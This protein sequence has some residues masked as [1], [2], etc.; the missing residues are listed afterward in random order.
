[1]KSNSET[2]KYYKSI[3]ENYEKLSEEDTIKYITLAQQ[4]DTFARDLIVNSYIYLVLN[5][6]GKY[7]GESLT[8][9]DFIQEG[10]MGLVD[11]IETYDIEKYK[12]CKFVQIA[13]TVI[14]RRCAKAYNTDSMIKLPANMMSIK[15]GIK[16]YVKNYECTYGIE[17]RISDIAEHFHIT[18]SQVIS[19]LNVVVSI[20]SFITE[21]QNLSEKSD[22]MKIGQE[23]TSN[24]K[25]LEEQE[26]NDK[27]ERFVESLTPKQN[28][29]IRALAGIDHEVLTDK[30]IHQKYGIS[31]ISVSTIKRRIRDAYIYQKEDVT[32]SNNTSKKDI[33]L[34]EHG[35]ALI[36]GILNQFGKKTKQVLSLYIGLDK[37]LTKEEI[38]EVTGSTLTTINR[39]INDVKTAISDR[40]DEGCVLLKNLLMEK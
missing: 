13:T 9:D 36:D 2:I 39:H 12:K 23:L 30:E 24:E 27:V 26:E 3:A 34:D 17:P 16:E 37:R 31:Q 22:Y 6:A 19:V 14:K 35:K 32:K 4:G 33:I 1:M 10:M 40:T 28:L 21:D 7:Y 5:L 11:A 8:E 25:K 15:R 18:S 38:V 29:V 20:N